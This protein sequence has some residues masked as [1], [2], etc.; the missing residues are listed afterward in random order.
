MSHTHLP[1][2]QRPT[3]LNYHLLERV[4]RIPIFMAPSRTQTVTG[5]NASP[6]HNNDPFSGPGQVLVDGRFYNNERPNEHQDNDEIPNENQDSN[7]RSDQ[8]HGNNADN[9]GDHNRVL[10]RGKDHHARNKGN[11]NEV[12]QSSGSSSTG[13]L[14]L[15]T[16]ASAAL[17]FWV[18]KK[19]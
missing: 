6:G 8:R 16:A 2:P 14:I 15:V 10:Q 9:T 7:A 5:M 1:I 13:T 11:K 4:L 18:L 3:R 17:L 12:H 19:L